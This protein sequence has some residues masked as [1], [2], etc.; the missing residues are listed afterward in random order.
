MGR[1]RPITGATTN[2]IHWLKEFDVMT[3]GDLTEVPTEIEHTD[4]RPAVMEVGDARWRQLPRRENEPVGVS[5]EIPPTHRNYYTKKGDG[6]HRPGRTGHRVHGATGR[7]PSECTSVAQY[8]NGCYQTV[9]TG[10]SA[11]TSE[12][13]LLRRGGW[14]PYIPSKRILYMV[15]GDK[16]VIEG[17]SKIDVKLPKD[18]TPAPPWIQTLQRI[19]REHQMPNNTVCFTDGSWAA[20]TQIVHRFAQEP[21]PQGNVATAGIFYCADSPEWEKHPTIAIPISNG[22]LIRAHSAFPII[23]TMYGPGT[24]KTH[25]QN[26]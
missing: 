11:H 23:S 18:S 24:P 25:K 17:I 6:V 26:P 3:I 5:E 21:S 13:V 15:Y 9:D 7:N 19:F 4:Q 20:A 2:T 8:D 22:N 10:H 14:A 16:V 1:P 12:P